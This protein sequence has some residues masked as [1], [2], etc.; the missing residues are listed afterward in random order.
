M[1]IEK[2]KLKFINAEKYFEFKLLRIFADSLINYTSETKSY[3][4]NRYFKRI[5]DIY[6]YGFKHQSEEQIKAI[7]T[8]YKFIKQQHNGI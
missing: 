2:E 6:N 5:E 7:H 4:K 3:M 8:T 1:N